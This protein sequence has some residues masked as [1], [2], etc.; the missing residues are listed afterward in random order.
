MMTQT[1]SYDVTTLEQLAL[2]AEA[3]ISQGTAAAVQNRATVIALSGDL[4]AGKTTFVQLLANELGLTESVTSPTFVIM[5]Q[6][7]TNHA[8]FATLVHIDAYRIETADEMRPLGFAAIVQ[9]PNTLVCIEWAEKIADVLPQVDY[10]IE[11]ALHATGLRTL[12]L[13]T[14]GN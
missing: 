4:G 6:Y 9:Q 3:V 5:K 11:L 1:H 13:T 7:E 10:R 14:Y 8:T 12:N 2:V